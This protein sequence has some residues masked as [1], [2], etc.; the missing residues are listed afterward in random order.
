MQEVIKRIGIKRRYEEWFITDY[1][2][3]DSRIYDLL[4]EYESSSELNYLA[5]Q[6]MEL[7]ESEDFWQ[8]VLD[9]GE[10]TGSVRDLINL[11]KIWIALIIF[12]VSPMI[13]FSAIIGLRK[14]AVTT[15]KQWALFQTI[16][17]MRVSGVIFALMK[18]AYLPT[19]AMCAQM[20]AALLTSTT[21]ILRTF[22]KNTVF[23]AR[24][25]MF[26][27]LSEEQKKVWNADLHI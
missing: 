15:Q 17:T 9:L 21:A 12:R 11:P 3:P 27:L 20:A 25:S 22:P 13:L 19:T 16:L 23:K 10:N 8:A 4:G 26:V 6:I 1:E 24:I 2:C 14:A 18:A 7:D 5:N